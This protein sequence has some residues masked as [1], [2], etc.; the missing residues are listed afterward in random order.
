MFVDI[1]LYYSWASIMS[2]VILYSW[3]DREN[4][5]CLFEVSELDKE[6]DIVGL[7]CL[8]NLKLGLP[9]DQSWKGTCDFLLRKYN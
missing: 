1:L 4:M 5:R 8:T 2:L 9:R 6:C 7:L 3:H